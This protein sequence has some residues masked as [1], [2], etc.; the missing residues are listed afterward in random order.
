MCGYLFEDVLPHLS[1][2]EL[3][4]VDEEDLK[5]VDDL[6]SDATTRSKSVDGVGKRFNELS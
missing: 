3:V 2:D 4:S 1:F 5:V 6:I